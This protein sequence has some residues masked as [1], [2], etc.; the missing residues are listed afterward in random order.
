M[1]WICM[2]E[3]RSLSR[4]RSRR[5]RYSLNTRRAPG[6]AHCC[7][8]TLSRVMPG[9]DASPSGS[10]YPDTQASRL[11]ADAYLDP[12]TATVICASMPHDR[13]QWNNA[14]NH[15]KKKVRCTVRPRIGI[16]MWL[17][18]N[19]LSILE[20]ISQSTVRKEIWLSQRHV[21]RRKE[22]PN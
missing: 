6:S 17:S 7:P 10:T 2:A 14:P 5:R 13:R 20:T 1:A 16:Q 8:S 18:N 9:E 21:E 11:N 15:L 19:T 4:R 22:T 12:S 3:L